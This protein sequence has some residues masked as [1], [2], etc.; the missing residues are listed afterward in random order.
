MLNPFNLNDKNIY[1]LSLNLTLL[2]SL[3]N[4]TKPK[5]NTVSNL[6]PIFKDVS[7]FIN[8]NEKIENLLNALKTLPF[9]TS[10]EFIDRYVS[11]DGQVSYTIKFQFVND[12][13]INSKTIEDYL[14]QIYQKM[15]ESNCIVRK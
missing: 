15:V 5:F 1:C 9:I 14:N 13:T 8:E 4:E 12:K 6:Q 3:H 10:Y 11:N 2:L 7:F